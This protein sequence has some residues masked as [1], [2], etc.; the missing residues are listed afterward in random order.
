[1]V[2]IPNPKKPF[3]WPGELHH[4][5]QRNESAQEKVKERS[6]FQDGS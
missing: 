6:L 3:T 5:E 4:G 1:M 2:H